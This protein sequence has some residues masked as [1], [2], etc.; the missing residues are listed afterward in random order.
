ML[1]TFLEDSS[2]SR[3]VADGSVGDVLSHLEIRRV[4][5]SRVQVHEGTDRNPRVVRENLEVLLLAVVRR[6]RVPDFAGI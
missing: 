4:L 2:W 3:K 6:E 5:G 1:T